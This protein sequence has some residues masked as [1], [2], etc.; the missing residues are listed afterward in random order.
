[1]LERIL[2]TKKYSINKLQMRE[3][4][5]LGS[6]FVLTS[7]RTTQPLLWFWGMKILR[8][9]FTKA[10]SILLFLTETSAINLV[11]IMSSVSTCGSICFTLWFITLNLVLLLLFILQEYTNLCLLMEWLRLRGVRPWNPWTLF[12]GM[13]F[14]TMTIFVPAI[15]L[16]CLLLKPYQCPNI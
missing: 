11:L 10:L 5:L 1:M 8:K 15:V 13:Q 16:I 7:C 9:L 4:V 14:M 2:F 6:S 12:C 3:R